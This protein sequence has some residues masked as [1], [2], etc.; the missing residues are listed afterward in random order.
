MSGCLSF[1]HTQRTLFFVCLFF[2]RSFVCSFFLMVFC[3][4]F[5]LV[6]VVLRCVYVF[7]GRGPSVQKRVVGASAKVAAIHWGCGLWAPAV[8]QRHTGP[9]GCRSSSWLGGESSA[10]I[11]FSGISCALLTSCAA[12]RR[13][14]WLP[15]QLRAVGWAK[16][17][18]CINSKKL[19]FAVDI[20]CREAQEAAGCGCCSRLWG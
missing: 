6:V 12:R 3:L 5:F 20:L 8:L 7:G 10:Q 11:A 4:L 18:G 2:W 19:C 15:E 17:K 13:T 16:G 1:S 14:C 9:A